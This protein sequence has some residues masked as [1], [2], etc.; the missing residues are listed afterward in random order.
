[1]SRKVKNGLNR[2]LI[3][4]RGEAEHGKMRFGAI[5]FYGQGL[6]V[7]DFS[8]A[9]AKKYVFVRRAVAGKHV[10]SPHLQ[11]SIISVIY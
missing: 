6:Y 7:Y 10:I 8:A 9:V 1:M 3:P 5:F 4:F 2:T 11:F